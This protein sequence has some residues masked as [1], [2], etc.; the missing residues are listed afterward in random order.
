MA[1][2]GLVHSR[3]MRCGKGVVS[4]VVRAAALTGG[5]IMT[6][7]HTTNHCCSGPIPPLGQTK[8]NRH[9]H[10]KIPV[11]LFPRNGPTSHTHGLPRQPRRSRRHRPGHRARTP[12][13]IRPSPACTR[14]RGHKGGEHG[15]PVA[16]SCATVVPRGVPPVGGSGF[17]ARVNC[18]STYMGVPCTGTV[19]ATRAASA[20]CFR[21][22]ALVPEGPCVCSGHSDCGSRRR[23]GRHH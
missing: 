23:N 8:P 9:R 21:E 19:D 16:V 17:E 6:D 4:L 14:R 11:L 15:E 18:E 22:R 2:L 10:T 7:C 12:D 20:L 3:I 1:Q 13:A 5:C